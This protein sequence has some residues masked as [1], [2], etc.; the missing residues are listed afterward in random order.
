MAKVTS[1]AIIMPLF[2]GSKESLPRHQD[3]ELVIDWMY[4]IF[5]AWFG[6]F[7]VAG[8][9]FVLSQAFQVADRDASHHQT[10]GEIVAA[11]GLG[12][13]FADLLANNFVGIARSVM[14]KS[15][16][17]D[18]LYAGV[19]S[20]LDAVLFIC[21][22][23]LVAKLIRNERIAK[24]LN[25]HGRNSKDFM[26]NLRTTLNTVT[27]D[28]VCLFTLFLCLMRYFEPLYLELGCNSVEIVHDRHSIC[29]RLLRATIDNSEAV[30]LRDYL[31]LDAVIKMLFVKASYTGFVVLLSVAFV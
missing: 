31:K 27:G 21:T 6:L 26:V 25:N 14:E 9:Y 30:S 10:R 8:F 23:L 11:A 15:F 29:T 18:F 3:D 1:Q 19:G 28:P 13:S 5:K 17:L 12:W 2:L 16:S 22:A 7:D 20:N 24:K 4:H